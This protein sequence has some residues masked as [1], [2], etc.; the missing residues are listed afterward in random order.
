VFTYTVTDSHGNTQTST[1]TI[2]VV[3][4][5][6]TAGSGS[7]TVNEDGLTG[8]LPGQP[9]DTLPSSNVATG[10]LSVKYGADGPATTD[11]ISFASL[12]GQTVQDTNLKDLT[13]G[14]STMHYVWDGTTGTLSAVTNSAETDPFGNVL[15]AGTVVFTVA[16]NEATGGYTFTLDH[17]LDGDSSYGAGTDAVLSLGY[18]ASDFDNSTANGTLTLA[19]LDDTPNNIVP[20]LAVLGN[21]ST[22]STTAL[23]SITVPLDID[24]NVHNNYGAD[25]IGAT[26]QFA[27]SLQGSNSGLT[28]DGAP[29]YYSLSSNGEELIATAN[30]Q[31]VFTITLNLN[32]PDLTSTGDTYTINM[33]GPVDSTTTI[34]FSSGGYTFFGGN[35]A[36][37]G[38]STIT[39][40]TNPDLLATPI[41]T[42][43]SGYQS[44]GTINGN[45]NEFGVN[46]GN[47][48]GSGEGVRLDFVNNL[49]GNPGSGK[50]YSIPANQTESYTTH[51]TTNGATEEILL[52]NGSTD[53]QLA[54]IADTS[55]ATHPTISEG[56]EVNLTAVS[57]NYNGATVF[58]PETNQNFNAAEN[59]TVGGHTF[60]V[61]FVTDTSGLGTATVAE[62]G[63]IVT[64]TNLGVFTATG[65]GA[66]ETLYEGGNDFKIGGFGASVPSTQPVD[67]SVPLTITDGDGDTASGAI[68]VSLFPSAETQF[69]STSGPGTYTA[70][71]ARP[72]IVDE[73]SGGNNTLNGLNGTNDILYGGHGDTLNAGTIGVDILIAGPGNNILN[74]TTNATSTSHD[75]FVLQVSNG[76]HQSIN[77]FNAT[78]DDIIVD[79]GAGGT[80]ASAMAS[81]GLASGDLVSGAGTG[82]GNSNPSN[83]FSTGNHFAFNTS[84]NEL[85]Y[86]P[87][88]T[89]AHA[90][91]LAH[92]ATGV[93]TAA[94]IHTM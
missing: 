17:Q 91:D 25:Q 72:N 55:S 8:G 12:K 87:D 48:I 71:S 15:A 42:G 84:T 94:H 75:E 70:T 24:G 73:S 20:G 51:Y 5:V 77:N 34:N 26:T 10:N 81:S 56:T 35:G 19:V 65:Y 60:T 85:Y 50:D 80:I 22:Y 93:P 40:T 28:S 86:S 36:Y 46:G 61:E 47:S 7:A 3:D 63:S 23:S 69:V 27:S 6:P 21:P 49:T 39:S 78:Y 90:I 9:L 66:L 54:A 1:L 31:Q 43:A 89:A 79:I 67:F 38:Y 57:I 88:A 16:I 58:V 76:A 82:T 14:G 44:G 33:Y 11:P 37:A 53:V 62:V 18:T 92:L 45:A 74:G 2:N 30:G 68:G 59:V 13:S 52:T 41:D 4:D 29:I 32:A 64:G 83:L